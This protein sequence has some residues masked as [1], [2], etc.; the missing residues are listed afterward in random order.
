MI[1]HYLPRVKSIGGY[2]RVDNLKNKT[3][4]QVRQLKDAGY[5]YFYFGVESGDDKLLDRMNKGY[6][7]DYVL[8]ECH[9]MD[10]A[11]MPWIANFL[12]GLEGTAGGC[13]M[14]GKQQGSIIS[15]NLP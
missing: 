2:A 15:S 7:A 5:N 13:P 1:Y 8:H 6:H 12:G 3:V 10:E 4:E 11:G 14:H 9:K